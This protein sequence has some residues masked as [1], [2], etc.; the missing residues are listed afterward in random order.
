M[1]LFHLFSIETKT[2]GCKNKPQKKALQSPIMVRRIAVDVKNSSGRNCNTKQDA[3]A[4]TKQSNEREVCHYSAAAASK[5]LNYLTPYGFTDGFSHAGY[6]KFAVDRFNMGV[7]C[8]IT[9]T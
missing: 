6:M 7:Y 4:A 8:I 3:T 2:L 1:L 9:H 5:K